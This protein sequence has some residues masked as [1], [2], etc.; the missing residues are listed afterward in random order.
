MYTYLSPLAIYSTC[1]FLVLFLVT[2][3]VT[4]GAGGTP[5]TTAKQKKNNYKTSVFITAITETRYKNAHAL[6]QTH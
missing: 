2:D 3:R 4:A 1:H 5:K 6:N